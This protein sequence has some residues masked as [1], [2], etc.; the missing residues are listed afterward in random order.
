MWISS[1]H[2]FKDT[3]DPIKYPTTRPMNVLATKRVRRKKVL[4]T[5][6][7][8]QKAPLRGVQGDSFDATVLSGA[9]L[10]S[11]PRFIQQNFQVLP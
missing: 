1:D 6:I 4:R 5:Y 3:K 10:K 2:P 11:A 7:F 8:S 9:D